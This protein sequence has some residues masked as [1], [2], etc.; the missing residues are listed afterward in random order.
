[1]TE[2]QVYSIQK[3]TTQSGKHPIA[4]VFSASLSLSRKGEARADS[5]P[6]SVPVDYAML[7]SVMTGSALVAQAA[8]M[9]GVSLLCPT[10][11]MHPVFPNPTRW[12]FPHLVWILSDQCRL[13]Y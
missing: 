3:E 5:Q 7:V 4:S 13:S 2:P 10:L 6:W 1:M 9:V 12:T 8:T 11:H